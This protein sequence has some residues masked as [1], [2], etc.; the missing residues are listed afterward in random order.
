MG[1]GLTLEIPDFFCNLLGLRVGVGLVV[2]FVYEA[3]YLAVGQRYDF[4][5]PPCLVERE[6]QVPF[7]VSESCAVDF[8][9]VA[10]I[11]LLFGYF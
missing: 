5:P 10:L 1:C 9:D 2:D 7:C 6:R 4:V 11:G 3:K 8:E